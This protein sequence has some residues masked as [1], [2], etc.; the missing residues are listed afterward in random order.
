MPEV[1][2]FTLHLLLSGQ[3]T[4]PWNNVDGVCTALCTTQVFLLVQVE[5]FTCI[6]QIQNVVKKI[7]P[8][9]GA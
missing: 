8:C 9:T 5:L 6:P 3:G 4:N 7:C 1:A 2:W